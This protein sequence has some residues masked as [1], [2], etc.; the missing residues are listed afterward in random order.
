VWRRLR[1]RVLEALDG[2][3]WL[4]VGRTEG[5]CGFWGVGVCIFDWD[6]LGV[7]GFGWAGGATQ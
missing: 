7:R 2:C 4:G 1:W 6:L 3:V 5:C